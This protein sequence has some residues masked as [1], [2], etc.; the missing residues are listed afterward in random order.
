MRYRN[1]QKFYISEA[2]Y[3]RLR[4]PLSGIG[5][6]DP[7]SDADREYHIRSLY[8]DDI[9]NT[10]L[11]DKSDGVEFRD[12]Y[13]IRMYKM[14]PQKLNLE[15]KIKTREFI[16]KL[17]TPITQQDC[18][19]IFD[20]DV[21]FL[22]DDN[23]VHQRYFRRIRSGMQPIVVVDY[24]R[25]AYTF[26]YE[27]VRITFDKDVRTGLYAHDLFSPDYPTLA[28]LPAGLMVLEVKFNHFLPDFLRSLLSNV[29]A[30][31][32]AISKYVMCRRFSEAGA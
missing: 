22:T 4:G 14:D 11:H 21:A 12:K 31:R 23:E 32:S 26:P 15:I 27:D 9:Y 29:P 1:E 13:R 10:A 28:V 16:S 19:R 25:E 2:T 30:Q 18:Q 8:F 6:L 3:Y 7:N 5:T 20:G 17:S 24:R